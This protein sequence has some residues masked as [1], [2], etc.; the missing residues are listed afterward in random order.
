MSAAASCLH[1][2]RSSSTSPRKAPSHFM[3]D[4]TTRREVGEPRRWATSRPG[5][6]DGARVVWTCWR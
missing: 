4:W 2:P 6:T 3:R 1:T 5:G